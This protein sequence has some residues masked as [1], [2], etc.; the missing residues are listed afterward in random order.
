MTVKDLLKGLRISGFH[1]LVISLFKGLAL[2]KI[3]YRLPILD[4]HRTGD[5]LRVSGRQHIPERSQFSDML[6][7]LRV[8]RLLENVF[9]IALLNNGR[10]D[11]ISAASLIRALHKYLLHILTHTRPS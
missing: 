1:C 2:Y 10:Y 5:D 9:F 3:K 11:R 4:P 8:D 7:P 6:L